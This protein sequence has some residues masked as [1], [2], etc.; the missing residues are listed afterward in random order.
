MLSGDC[1]QNS[2]E[3][4]GDAPFEVQSVQAAMNIVQR[5]MRLCDGTLVQF[6][7]DEKG[8]LAICAF[9]LP[10]KTHENG[11]SRAIQAALG[12]VAAMKD[13]GQVN[14]GFIC[15]FSL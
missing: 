12:I 7:C 13:I 4:E 14:Q 15:C 8:F 1:L 5:H 2:V 3:P 10:G 9:G 11:A 6:R